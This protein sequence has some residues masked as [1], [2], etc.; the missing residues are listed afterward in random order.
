[1]ILVHQ[2][3]QFK[4]AFNAHGTVLKFSISVAICNSFHHNYDCCVLLNHPIYK[5]LTPFMNI[6]EPPKGE[7]G[8]SQLRVL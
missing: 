2:L 8:Y 7:G 1:M 3:Q 6:T 5:F 4:Y